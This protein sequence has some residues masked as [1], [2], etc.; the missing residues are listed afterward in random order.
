MKRPLVTLGLLLA[1]VS[2]RKTAPETIRVDPNAPVELVL[3]EKGAYTGAFIDFGDAEDAVALE[4]IED[5][6]QIVGKHQA[7]HPQLCT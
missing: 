1:L 7:S 2:C 5:L 4:T 3:P 6:E